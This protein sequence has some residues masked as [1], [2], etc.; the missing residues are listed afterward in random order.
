MVNISMKKWP[1]AKERRVVPRLELYLNGYV[2]LGERQVSCIVKNASSRGALLLLSEPID[3]PKTFTLHIIEPCFKAACAQRHGA[4]GVVGVEFRSH[5]R[6]AEQY[7]A[8]P[9]GGKL[10]NRRR[11]AGLAV[12]SSKQL[13]PH[14]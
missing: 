7:F 12:L 3:L 13:S 4:G 11:K 6:E 14:L 8:S 2:Q 10:R 9:Y 1:K 5:R